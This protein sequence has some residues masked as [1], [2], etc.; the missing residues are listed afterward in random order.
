M[1]YQGDL[2]RVITFMLSAELSTR[3]YPNIGVADGHHPISHNNFVPE[4]MAKKAKV[5]AYHVE[6]VAKFPWTF[7]VDSSRRRDPRFSTTL[8]CCTVAA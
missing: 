4:Q 3:S 6:R 8:H 2:T 1:A 7:G 5:D